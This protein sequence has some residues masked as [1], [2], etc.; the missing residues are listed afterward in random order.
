MLYIV[1]TKLWSI[2]AA[3]SVVCNPLWSRTA[4]Y[5]SGTHQRAECMHSITLTSVAA[6]REREFASMSFFHSLHE[7]Q[8]VNQRTYV[9]TPALFFYFCFPKVNEY[10]Y[11]FKEIETFWG[12][13]YLLFTR[14]IEKSDATI[15]EWYWEFLTPPNQ[16]LMMS[17]AA[18]NSPIRKC[19]SSSAR[20]TATL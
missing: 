17:L 11:S 2:N 5:A 16:R 18:H 15:E 19:R 8:T 9:W 10:F 7:N 12:R 1:V 4:R 20:S 3:W 13:K 14:F 6:M